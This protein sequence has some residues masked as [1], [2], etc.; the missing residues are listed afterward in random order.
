M[1]LYFLVYNKTIEEHWK[2]LQVVFELMRKNQMYAKASK[3]SNATE[4]VEYLGH[5]ISVN[6]VDTDP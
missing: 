2:H 6:G 1:F 4:K 5:F 3:C